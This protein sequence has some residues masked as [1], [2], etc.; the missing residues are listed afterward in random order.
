MDSGVFSFRMK[1][2]ESYPSLSNVNPSWVPFPLFLQ[3]FF[4]PSG[5]FHTPISSVRQAGE[6]AKEMRLRKAKGDLLEFTGGHP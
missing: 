3:D 2:L 6:G 4:I 5:S 1:F